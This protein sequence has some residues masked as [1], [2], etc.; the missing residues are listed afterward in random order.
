MKN[1]INN[2]I[3]NS[4]YNNIKNNCKSLYDTY[5]FKTKNQKYKLKFILKACVHFISIY[6]SY[7]NFIYFNLNHNTFYKNLFK[8][9]KFKIFE[10]TYNDLLIVI[11]ISNKTYLIFITPFYILNADF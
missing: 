2:L 3:V 5:Q 6:C 11:K 1:N 9:N 7:K 8:L 10:S 4:I